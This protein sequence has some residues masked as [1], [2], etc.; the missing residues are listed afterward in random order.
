MRKVTLLLALLALAACGS[1]LPKPPPPLPLYRLTPLP[2]VAN[3][4]PVNVQLAVD[5]PVA[6][7]S[8][9]TDRIALMANPL[10]ID[11]FA[12]SSWS[13]RAPEMIQSLVIESLANAGRIRVATRPSGE[14]RNDAEL[15]IDLERF[16][17]EYQGGDLPEIHVRLVC[18]LVHDRNAIAVRTFD[19]TARPAHNDTADIVG[20]F[21]TAFHAVLVELAPWTADQLAALK[22]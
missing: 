8:L 10:R 19:A 17:A 15:M 14:V 18:R 9:D 22:P 13:D 21:D 11:Y 12:D 2:P 3:A 7:A 6:S 4:A 5:A 16:D 20:A 1:V